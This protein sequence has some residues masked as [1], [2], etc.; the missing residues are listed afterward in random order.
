MPLAS[1]WLWSGRVGE[2]LV[3]AGLVE[4]GLVG[5]Q[6]IALEASG[7]D[8]AVGVVEVIAGE[9]GVSLDAAQEGEQLDVAPFVVAHL[10]PRVVVLGDAA[11][12]DLAVDGAGAAG[13]L[14]AGNHHG[15]SSVGGLAPEL[16]VVVAGHDVGGGGVA[17]L[18]LVGQLLEVG[19]VAAGL[20]QQDR[21]GGVFAEAGGDDGAG[22]PGAD[23]DVVVF[24]GCSPNAWGR[25]GAMIRRGLGGVNHGNGFAGTGGSACLVHGQKV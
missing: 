23:D 24:H 10:G 25:F 2:P 18:D 22:G 5:Q 16:P 3:A 19:V 21:D 13:Y 4:G 12:E 6:L 17:E 15:R 9:I 7:D 1:G 11:E 8:G 14:A 20:E